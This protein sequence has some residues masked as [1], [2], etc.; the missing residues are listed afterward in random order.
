MA[1]LLGS[2]TSPKVQRIEKEFKDHND[3]F[4]FSYE[5]MFNILQLLQLHVTY[6]LRTPVS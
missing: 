3:T 4:V 6:Q 5:K 1:K 2:I